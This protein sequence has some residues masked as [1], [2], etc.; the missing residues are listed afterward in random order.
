MWNKHIYLVDLRQYAIV[1]H[2]PITAS[3]HA[4]SVHATW[5][6]AFADGRIKKDLPLFWYFFCARASFAACYFPFTSW[7]FYMQ[8]WRYFVLFWFIRID[9]VNWSHFELLLLY[10][11]SH[12]SRP[13]HGVFLIEMLVR[14]DSSR[15]LMFSNQWQSKLMFRKSTFEVKPQI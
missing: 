6:F 13:E 12:V 1:N 5:A 10:R 2:N 8:K 9:F 11:L 15:E 14:N 7:W 3:P 4:K